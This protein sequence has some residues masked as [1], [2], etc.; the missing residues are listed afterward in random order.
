MKAKTFAAFL[1]GILLAG[2][3]CAIAIGSNW[4]S[5][6]FSKWFNSW[7]KGNV[8]LTLP[9]DEQSNAEPHNNAVINT[10]ESRGMSLMSTRVALAEYDT[11]GIDAKSV[12]SV[13]DL[14]VTYTP[15]NTTYQNT[16]YT[17]SFA[18]SSS[19][20][21]TGKN[22]SNYAT[23]SQPQSGSKKAQVKVLQAFSEPIVIKATCDRYP[24]IYTTA[25]LNYVKLIKSFG[26][27]E[28]IHDIH[29]N[30]FSSVTYGEGTITP[31]GGL[32]TIQFNF[33]STDIWQLS[34]TK[35]E[36]SF[37]ENGQIEN[38]RMIDLLMDNA[39]LPHDTEAEFFQNYSDYFLSGSTPE[40]MVN[41]S[42]ITLIDSFTVSRTYNGTRYTEQTLNQ[43]YEEG[44]LLYD[45]TPFEIVPTGMVSNNSSIVAG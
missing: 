2:V 44:I 1:C 40:D 28:M 10:E 13:Y 21:A 30:I 26:I 17:I 25:S 45:W 22:I 24:E 38:L 37:N 18:N 8:S 3:I 16:T 27:N 29:D 11:Y 31:S 32:A 15:A 23:I 41:C 35:N 39:K 36:Y 12:D 7:G 33:G 19:P 34:T 6:P 43:H 42:I 14:S 4:F 20:W 9:G 5:N